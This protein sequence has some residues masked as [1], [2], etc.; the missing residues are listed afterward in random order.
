MTYQGDASEL[1]PCML[2]SVQPRWHLE[3]PGSISQSLGSHAWQPSTYPEQIVELGVFGHVA[4][5]ILRDERGLKE[6]S[7]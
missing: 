5:F 6:G 7:T 2:S 4:G 1:R 3:R